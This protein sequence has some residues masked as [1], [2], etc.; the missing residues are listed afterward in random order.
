MAFSKKLRP[1]WVDVIIAKLT[2][3]LQLF[4]LCSIQPGWNLYGDAHMEIAEAVALHIFDPFTLQT[5][6]GPILSA[7]RHF[8]LFAAFQVGIVLSPSR[9]RPEQS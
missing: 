3:F 2:K 1:D 9:G 8:N 4:L 5:K 6:D 7:G